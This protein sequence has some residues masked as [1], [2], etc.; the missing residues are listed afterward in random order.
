MS[1]RGRLVAGCYLLMVLVAVAVWLIAGATSAPDSAVATG[2]D[3]ALVLTVPLGLLAYGAVAVA[4]MALTGHG[5]L[6]SWILAV[7]T[8]VLFVGSAVV[9]VIAVRGL[10]RWCHGRRRARRAE[11]QTALAP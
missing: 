1:R 5:V 3:T 2:F 6:A 10:W 11:G 4:A 8:V 9:N 7:V